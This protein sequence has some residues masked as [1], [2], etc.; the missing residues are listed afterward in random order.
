[1]ILLDYSLD[2]TPALQVYRLQVILMGIHGVHSIQNKVSLLIAIILII[3]PIIPDNAGLD[4]IFDYI[5]PTIL[6]YDK[7]FEL[8]VKGSLK[9][10]QLK[11]I[12]KTLI[13]GDP[14]SENSFEKVLLKKQD[15]FDFQPPDLSQYG[16][17]DELT[18]SIYFSSGT[19]GRSKG[20]K[21]SHSLLVN[22]IN[23]LLACPELSDPTLNILGLSALRWITQLYIMIIPI[24][25]GSKRTITGKDPDPVNICR[26]IDKWNVTTI[27]GTNQILN[28]VF[29]NYSKSFDYNFSSVQ[30]ILTGGESPCKSINERINKIL[31]NVV[32]TYG[33]GVSECGGA[34]ALQNDLGYLN[35]GH[36]LRGFSARVVDENGTNIDPGMPGIVHIKGRAKFT[37]YFKNEAATR[38]AITD[39]GWYDTGDYGFIT[40]SN[41]LHI[42]GRYNSIPKCKGKLI[43]AVDIKEHLNKHKLVDISTMV[44]VPGITPNNQKIDVYVKLKDGIVIDEDVARAILT[45]Y[46]QEIVDGEIVEKLEIVKG[47]KVFSTGKLISVIY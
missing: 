3:T 12:R 26:A 40:T 18:A 47:F 29:N 20:I 8:E 2:I 17:P 6:I 43:F 22:E 10:L 5:R 39:D 37:G 13:Y 14:S 32:I 28:S 7:E 27:A 19:T 15:I 33:Y 31:P 21:I 46:L 1:M 36:I 30:V 41:H 35:G 45:K 42:H 4:S 24:F 11:E 9:R 23:G 16:S 34:I 44:P 38:K 25:Y